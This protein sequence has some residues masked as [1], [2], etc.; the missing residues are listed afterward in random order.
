MKYLVL[1]FDDATLDFYTNV[2][3]ILKKYEINVTLNVITGFS[4]NS[5]KHINKIMDFEQIKEASANGNE[6]AMHSDSH[7]RKID[8]NDYQICFNKLT[9][10]GIKQYGLALP[11]NQSIPAS[12]LDYAKE[13]NF[14]IQTGETYKSSFLEKIIVKL[15]KNKRYYY[16]F[17][18]N[19]IDYLKNKTMVFNRIPIYLDKAPSFYIEN[20]KN[21]RG[22][23]LIILMFHQIYKTIED[24]QRC[25]F[26]EGSWTTGYLDNLIK[27]CQKENIKIITMKD[28]YSK[29]NNFNFAKSKAL[30]Q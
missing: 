26:P 6:I 23:R 21:L 19:T 12:I 20:I 28:F 1:S 15:N 22:N 17:K 18:K 10:L 29:Y 11:F 2:M 24:C 7:S 5:Y 9:S 14:Y 3:P 4:D 27:E 13:N 30:Y 8:L 25:S 16:F